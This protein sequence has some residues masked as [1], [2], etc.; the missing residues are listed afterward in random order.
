MNFGENENE[1][2]LGNG[3]NSHVN[4]VFLCVLFYTENRGKANDRAEFAFGNSNYGNYDLDE[5][6]SDGFFWPCYRFSFILFN[7]NLDAIPGTMAGCDVA[8]MYFF[9]VGYGFWLFYNVFIGNFL[10][11]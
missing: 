7:C 5:S 1:L 8:G 9:D 3:D 2:G 4:W 11:W 10:C 6:L